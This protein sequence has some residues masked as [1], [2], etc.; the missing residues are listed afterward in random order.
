MTFIDSRHLYFCL[1]ER[2]IVNPSPNPSFLVGVNPILLLFCKI[3]THVSNFR[4]FII[5]SSSTIDIMTFF[6]S[7]HLYFCLKER[8]IVNPSPNPSFLV[9]GKP[10]FALILHLFGKI[11]THVSNFRF[12]FIYSSSTID[13]MT[14]IDSRHLC[15][16]LKERFIVNQSPNTSFLVRVNP[17]LLLFCIYLQNYPPMYQNLD[18]FPFIVH[19][20]LIL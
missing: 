12:F 11:P 14:F 20:L 5:Y 15:F 4:F 9:L 6:D 2:F 19:L 18:F 17:I 3:P 8:F 7:R 13:I 10:Y 16:C 1:K